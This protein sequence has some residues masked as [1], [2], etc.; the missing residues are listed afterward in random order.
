MAR[1]RNDFD[2]AV[3]SRNR[4]AAL[5]GAALQGPRGGG[6]A[7]T[8]PVRANEDIGWLKAGETKTVTFKVKGT[9]ST[10]VTI[11]STRGGVDS[12]TLDIK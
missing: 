4:D 10:K 12:T 5:G 3:S 6:A 7:P 8:G 9:G 1:R 11:G 2:D